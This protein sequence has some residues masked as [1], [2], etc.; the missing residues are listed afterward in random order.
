[1]RHYRSAVVVVLRFFIVAAIALIVLGIGFKL[2]LDGFDRNDIPNLVFGLALAV[3]SAFFVVRQKPAVLSID[4]TGEKITVNKLLSSGETLGIVKKMEMFAGNR[5]II[6]YA[7]G[8]IVLDI[9][10]FG[11]WKAMLDDLEKATRIKIENQ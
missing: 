11:N 1:M 6:Y 10:N 3:C 7:G 8:T 2:S 9:H 5:L 4:I